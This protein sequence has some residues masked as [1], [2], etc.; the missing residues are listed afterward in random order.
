MVE[1]SSSQLLLG[2]SLRQ[3]LQEKTL[4]DSCKRGTV[5]HRK[6]HFPLLGPRV[7]SDAPE[8]TWAAPL[9]GLAFP[10]CAGIWKIVEAENFLECHKKKK[11]GLELLNW[12]FPNVSAKGRQLF[13]LTLGMFG[14]KIL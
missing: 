1:D 9:R 10:I 13:F 14:K 7:C 11:K 6:G 12:A 4:G 3:D 2:G 8:K 5:T